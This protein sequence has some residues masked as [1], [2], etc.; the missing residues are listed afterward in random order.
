MLPRQELIEEGSTKQ[1]N[2]NA[3]MKVG[4]ELRMKEEGHCR[5]VG[6]GGTVVYKSL[7]GGFKLFAL[8]DFVSLAEVIT[9]IRPSLC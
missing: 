4:L 5:R 8:G 3:G 9:H 1:V 2:L 6:R 7:R